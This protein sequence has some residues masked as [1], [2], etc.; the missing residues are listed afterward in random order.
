MNTK[1][2]KIVKLAAAGLFLL[3]L[4]IN[5]KVTLED[6]F[7]MVS[8][9]AMASGSDDVSSSDG[10]SSAGGGWKSNYPI[11]GTEEVKVLT[12]KMRWIRNGINMLPNEVYCGAFTFN[13]IPG[14]HACEFEWE[15]QNKT[16]RVCSSGF[17]L[18]LWN[19]L[20]CENRN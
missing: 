12:G 20:S 17:G 13:G 16:Q 14:F 2:N 10:G 11:C 3:A 19:D 5:V 7:V 4:A 15:T 6:P 8:E 1:V 18:C 9:Q